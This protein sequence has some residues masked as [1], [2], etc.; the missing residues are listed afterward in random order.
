MNIPT[1]VTNWAIIGISLASVLCAIAP[2]LIYQNR[3]VYAAPERKSA[4]LQSYSP[5]ETIKAFLAPDG[6]I[7]RGGADE[8]V[9]G[10]DKPKYKKVFESRFVMPC[11]DGPKLTVA[12]AHNTALA[13]TSN[14]GQVFLTTGNDVQGFTLGYV[15]GRSIGT[16]VM[17]PVHAAEAKFHWPLRSGQI[18]GT[19]KV[20]VDE[21]WAKSR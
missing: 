18:L 10:L 3:L 14:G 5:D 19:V 6:I 8:G 21:T 20:T 4:F 7:S 11:D 15:D 16:V 13:I 1:R 2:V 17:T 9:A 12:L